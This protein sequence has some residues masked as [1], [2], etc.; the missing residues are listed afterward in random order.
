MESFHGEPVPGQAYAKIQVMLDRVT[1]H[2]SDTKTYSILISPQIL[3]VDITS[4]HSLPLASSYTF[5]FSGENLDSATMMAA[6]YNTD[7]QSKHEWEKREITEYDAGQLF[8]TLATLNE[9]IDNAA[10]K[11]QS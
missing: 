2:M 11:N 4:R 6:T 9:H 10:R 3:R 1:N 5:A 8:D 7:T